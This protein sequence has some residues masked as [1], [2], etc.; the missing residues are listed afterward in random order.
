MPFPHSPC[1]PPA[2]RMWMGAV[3][4]T[5]KRDTL[6]VCLWGLHSLSKPQTCLFSQ[7]KWYNLFLRDVLGALLCT[8]ISRH[9][10]PQSL[11]MLL[12]S[13]TFF[14][15]TS[16]INEISISHLTRS[17]YASSPF[18]FHFSQINDIWSSSNLFSYLT[19]S[20]NWALAL[21]ELVSLVS[22]RQ[23]HIFTLH[24]R[25]TRGVS[26][27]LL[28]PLSLLIIFGH[29][30]RLLYGGFWVDSLKGWSFFLVRISP[31]SGLPLCSIFI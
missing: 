30:Q 13:G 18:L 12:V 15:P 20:N 5:L 7:T 14:F 6:T 22:E 1:S 21:A 23:V 9:I 16:E 27:V 29:T 31:W 25:W 10:S 8:A 24:W 28:E 2:H 11:V 26:T 3:F 19:F 17:D 4:L